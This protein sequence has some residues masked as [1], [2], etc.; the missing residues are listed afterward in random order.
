MNPHI[1][2]AATNL[3]LAMARDDGTA[4]SAKECEIYAE[5]L[6]WHLDNEFKNRAR[7]KVLPKT[8]MEKV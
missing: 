7:S 2:T 1:T 8:E 6:R 4:I 3:T 5:Q